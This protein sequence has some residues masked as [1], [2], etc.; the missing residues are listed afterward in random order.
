MNCRDVGE[1]VHAY[2]DDELDIVTARQLD[3]HL[4]ECSRCREALQGVQAVR[5]AVSNPAQY[6]KAP[7]ELRVRVLAA[8]RALSAEGANLFPLPLEGD[9][10]EGK[11][12][13]SRSAYALT[14]TLSQR[15]RGRA[16]APRKWW[17][18][19]AAAMIVLGGGLF[20]MLRG[21]R[22]N[23]VVA[24][25]LTAHLRS[26]QPGHLMDVVS[27]NQ[28]TV[29]PWFDTHIDF[30]PPV[31]QLAPEF[32]LV[33]GRLDYLENRPV[34]VL[35]YKHGDHLI[36][37]FIWPGDSGQSFVAQRGFNFV[38]WTSDGMTFWAVSDLATADLNHFSQLFQSAPAP[39]T[40]N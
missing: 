33:G 40:R 4:R 6:Y 10:S 20:F 31:R 34:A 3:Q 1:L 21:Q 7:P 27:T 30:S 5:T 14:P 22:E 28:H 16:R 32:P 17:G 13:E 12:E 36:N 15:E 29:K 25:V 38:H 18:V 39:A 35:I 8:T 26:L 9:R 37:L 11:M 2:V 24:E 19:A 23:P